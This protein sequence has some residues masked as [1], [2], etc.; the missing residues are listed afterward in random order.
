MWS[1]SFRAQ[2]WDVRNPALFGAA[3]GLSPWH[4]CSHLCTLLS[5]EN[6]VIGV[7]L[8]ATI[9]WVPTIRLAQY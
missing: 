6:F 4:L 5:L 8:G 3:V 7:I 2:N 1:G 9:Y